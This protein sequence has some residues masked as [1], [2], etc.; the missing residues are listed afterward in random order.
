MSI[1]IPIDRT[2]DIPLKKQVYDQLQIRIMRGE[3]PS[4]VK[5]PSSRSLGDELQV[6]RN[7]IVEVY[8]Q[9]NSEGYLESRAGSGTYVAKEVFLEKTFAEQG[10]AIER[11]QPTSDVD[12]ID[13]RS[14]IPALNHFPRTTWG[15][16]AR[17]V[18]NEI[19][20][21][22]FGYGHPEGQ[23]ELRQ[24]LAR[25]L[26]RTRGVYCHPIRL[27]S[28]PEQHRH[29]LSSPSCW[30]LQIERRLSLKIRLPRK[31]R[32]FLCPQAVHCMPSQLMS[33]E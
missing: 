24:A 2:L 22:T 27:S 9:L 3:I 1:W 11:A 7:L 31:S 4:G 23:F 8:E 14:G 29:F 13:F 26:S 33:L 32:K 28:L 12:I 25:Y 20:S 10:D 19:P 30:F 21:L 5:L 16:I 17:R 6:S 18:Y 15:L